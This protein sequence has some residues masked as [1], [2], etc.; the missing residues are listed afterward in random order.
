MNSTSGVKIG[1]EISGTGGKPVLTLIHG[2]AGSQR[3]WD[4]VR[5]LLEP[6]FQLILL[7]L[8]GHGGVIPQL[9]VDLARLSESIATLLSR[10]VRGPRC[11][12]GYSMGGRIAL[13]VA[14]RFPEA[15]SRLA[16]I[17]TS[18]GIQDDGEREQR[19][20]TDRELAGNIRHQG[21][22]WFE[23][24][25]S[26]LPLFATQKDLT[27]DKQ[28]WLKRERLANDPEGLALALE[29]WGTGQQEWILPRLEELR[30]PTLLLAGAKDEKFCVLA[31]QMDELIPT[32]Q[33]L[34]IPEAGHAP[35]IEQPSSVA[36]ELISFFS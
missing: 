27:L 9:E 35:H 22:E 4:L 29:L 20:N 17:G 19:R 24:Y 36:Q 30:C 7:D 16:L 18:P 6:H 1:V 11:L 31:E 34:A 32:S 21:I 14:L 25:W 10:A 26:N 3:T 8:P 13:H 2:F 28:V 5:P 15:V 23:Q 12:C 33:Y